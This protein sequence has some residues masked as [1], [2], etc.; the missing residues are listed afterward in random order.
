M[1]APVVNVGTPTFF[2]NDWHMITTNIRG[3]IAQLRSMNM[4]AGQKFLEHSHRETQY[5]IVLSGQYVKTIHK[6][7]IVR[8]RGTG[9]LVV[10]HVAHSCDYDRPVRS[11]GLD[12]LRGQDN[13]QLT[14]N[15]I[16]ILNSDQL[17]VFTQGIS[18]SLLLEAQ[19]PDELSPLAVDAYASELLVGI[20]RYQSDR[21]SEHKSI[22]MSRVMERLEDLS[23]NP[24]T[25]NE[26]AAIALIHPGHLAREFRL[27]F[28]M[29]I[30][31]FQRQLRLQAAAKA[32]ID[33]APISDIAL[34]AGYSAQSQFT[35][36]FKRAFGI[37]PAQYRRE[38][39]A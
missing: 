36:A 29:P 25:I 2:K 10:S 33:G 24:A 31:T 4:R 19:K 6:Q 20:L 7:P 32:V 27:R 21:P 34:E 15:K 1:P 17:G 8:C 12:F 39:S 18:R 38:R 22:R 26:L 3:E 14:K 30:A 11:L 16:H 9:Y 13:E 37:T 5:E 23:Q 28:G 35:T